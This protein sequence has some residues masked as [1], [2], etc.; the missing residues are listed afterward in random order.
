MEKSESSHMFPSFAL[1]IKF[2][3]KPAVKHSLM[4]F[5]LF[6]IYYL[7]L[8]EKTHTLLI[9]HLSIAG[10]EITQDNI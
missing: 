9:E 1:V 8:K 5:L 10:G 3:N 4:S 2:I 6:R 7:F